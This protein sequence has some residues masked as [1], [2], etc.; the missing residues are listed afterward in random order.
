MRIAWGSLEMR[1]QT[2]F[3]VYIWPHHS[4]VQEGANHAPILLVHR[5]AFLIGIKRRR[6]GHRHRKRLGL[7]HIFSTITLILATRRIF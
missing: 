6:G 4:Q 5:L 7:V 2:H 3:K 1:A